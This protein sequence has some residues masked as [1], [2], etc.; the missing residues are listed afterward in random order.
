M[1]RPSWDDQFRETYQEREERWR[2]QRA[3]RRARGECPICAK[4]IAQCRCEAER[5]TARRDP[6]QKSL[7]P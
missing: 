2:R 3:E 5:A 4:P 7:F 6:R 1:S